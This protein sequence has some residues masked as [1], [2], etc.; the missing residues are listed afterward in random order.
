MHAKQVFLENEHINKIPV[1]NADYQL[2]GEY[3]RWDD[4]LY[5]KNF[6]CNLTNLISN[7][8]KQYIVANEKWNNLHFQNVENIQWE[9]I[10]KYLYKNVTLI[11][12]TEDEKRAIQCAF[13]NYS[14][15]LVSIKNMYDD[16]YNNRNN[17]LKRAL[18]MLRNLGISAYTFGN[19][20]ENSKFRDYFVLEM[21]KQ[22]KW[23]AKKEKIG[24][25]IFM[26]NYI[27]MSIVTQY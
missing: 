11:F 22:E 7:E 17:G 20:Q 27:R 8:G 21:K 1:V 19:Y 4:Q 10:E 12:Y 6:L 16:V 13:Y 24:K 23:G 18:D 3:S 14:A 5:I 26:R 25:R 9:D 2:L 15:K